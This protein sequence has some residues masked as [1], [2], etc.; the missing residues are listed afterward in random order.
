[1]R[2]G[3][4]GQHRIARTF[5]HHLVNLAAQTIHLIKLFLKCLFPTPSPHTCTLRERREFFLG[6]HPASGANAV[7]AKSEGVWGALGICYP[8]DKAKPER[9]SKLSISLQECGSLSKSKEAEEVLLEHGSRSLLHTWALATL[10]P[11]LS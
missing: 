7:T 2:V 11:F 1:M 10:N 4:R 9:K 3:G 8:P 5:R 6:T